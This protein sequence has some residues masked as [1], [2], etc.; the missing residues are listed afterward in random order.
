MVRVLL[1]ALAACSSFEGEGA[2]SKDAG[3]IAADVTAPVSD[4]STSSGGVIDGSFPPGAVVLRSSSHGTAMDD[5]S[6]T[7]PLPAELQPTDLL[8]ALV[9]VGNADLHTHLDDVQGWSKRSDSS[10]PSENTYTYVFTRPAQGATGPFV[11]KGPDVI[12]GV[13]WLFAVSGASEVVAVHRWDQ[14]PKS[15]FPTASLAV[16]PSDGDLLV[17][18]FVGFTEPAADIAWVAPAG[19]HVVERVMRGKRS[20]MAA[21][22]TA[23]GELRAGPYAAGTP[24]GPN[25]VFATAILLDVK[26]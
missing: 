26:K 14:P 4:A 21:W 1:L 23:G 22:G 5:A 24:A 11:A 25:I 16:P 3:A 12:S 7:V 2:P 8:V 18:A 9:D 17:A 10:G 15:S 19:F 13:A 20:G 6:I